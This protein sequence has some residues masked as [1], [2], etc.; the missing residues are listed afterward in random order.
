MNDYI[1]PDFYRFNRDS[2]ELVRWIKSKLNNVSSILDLGA[3]CGIIG[4]ELALVY[5]PARL[6]LVEVQEDFLTSLEQNIKRLSL[7]TVYSLN[8]LSFSEWSP[9]RTYDLIVCNPPYYLPGRGESSKDERRGMARSFRLDGWEALLAAIKRS[10]SVDGCAYLVL[11]DEKS[12]LKEVSDK[13]SFSGLKGKFTL[14]EDL[15]FL[16]LSGLNVD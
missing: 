1:Q 13:I 12:I 16:E 9:S 10:L 5:R 2:L 11:K 4:I 7:E 3:G 6:D 15:V 8:I 14:F